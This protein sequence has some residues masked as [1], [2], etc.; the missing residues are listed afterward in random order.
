MAI[1]AAITAFA[2]AIVVAASD[3]YNGKT[4]YPAPHR[5]MVKIALLFAL[6]R[7]MGQVAL[8]ISRDSSIIIIKIL[9][10]YA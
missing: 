9:H 8:S 1:I 6:I 7:A 3:R 10:R 2:A 4:V 5:P